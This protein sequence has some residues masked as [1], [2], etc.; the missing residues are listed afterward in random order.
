MSPIKPELG[1]GVTR[2][3]QTNLRPYTVIAVYKDWSVLIQRDRAVLVSGSVM[4]EQQSYEYFPNPHGDKL[5]I[6]RRADGYW[7]IAG[8]STGST[9]TLGERAHY[10]DPSS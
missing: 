4:S 7:R 8:K 9:F 5:H 10:D 2:Q 1:M 3:F 6:T